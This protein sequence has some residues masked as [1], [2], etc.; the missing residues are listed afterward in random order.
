MTKKKVCKSCK[1][2]YEEKECP[3]CKST[4]TATSFQ[5]KIAILNK[6]KSEI[7]KKMNIP[8]NGEFAIKV[9]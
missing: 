5:G 2:F 8:V 1:F 9:R 6:D 3:L 7:A 4:T